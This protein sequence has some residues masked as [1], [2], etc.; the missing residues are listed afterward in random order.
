M[1]S[2]DP[3]IN[4]II[5]TQFRSHLRNTYDVIEISGSNLLVHTDGFGQVTSSLFT[6][7]VDTSSAYTVVVYQ[8]GAFRSVTGQIGTV[9]YTN[10]EPVPV[11]IGGIDEGSTFDN[12]PITTMFDLLLYPYQYPSFSEFSVNISSPVEVGYT[13]AAGNKTFTWSTTH[14]ANITPNSVSIDDTTYST[15]LATGLTNDGTEV[16]ALPSSIQH[17]TNTSHVW[18]VYAQNTKS[19]TI[20]KTY[21]VNWYWRIYYGES[22]LDSLTES[23]IES[24]RVSS[25]ANTAA[26]TYNFQA[27]AFQYKYICYPSS[28]GT[29]TH[30]KDVATNLDVDMYSTVDVVSVTNTYGITTNYNIHRT[31]NK[32]GGA[33]TIQ[34]S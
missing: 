19:Q 8:N 14:S 16:I 9:Y 28:F 26:N 27:V 25:L 15:T 24:L 11:T 20:S 5:Y 17:T 1:G 31:L 6:T 2:Y 7:P 23:D 18:T 21:T 33:I 10:S 30:F 22:A 13:I 12:V 32:L 34:S 4:S 29:L 3:P